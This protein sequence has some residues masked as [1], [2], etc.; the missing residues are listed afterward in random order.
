MVNVEA[1]EPD[2]AKGLAVHRLLQCVQ[3]ILDRPERG[4]VV[5]RVQRLFDLEDAR[6][7]QIQRRSLPAVRRGRFIGVTRLVNQPVLP[8]TREDSILRAIQDVHPMFIRGQRAV[9]RSNGQIVEP[10]RKPRMGV[11]AGLRLTVDFDGPR[12]RNAVPTQYLDSRL[13]P[14]PITIVGSRRRVAAGCRPSDDE[15]FGAS[16]VTLFEEKWQIGGVVLVRFGQQVERVKVA[17]RSEY[18]QHAPM[19]ANGALEDHIP[20][21]ELESEEFQLADRIDRVRSE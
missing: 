4:G 19:E 2:I 1:E 7:L 15:S 17:R 14:G 9:E 16:L 3:D 21:G 8:M 6:P 20:L 18:R 13:E 5:A 10:P 11:A 12:N